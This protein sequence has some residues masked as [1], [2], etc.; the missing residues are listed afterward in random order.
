MLAWLWSP[1][2]CG[3]R[4]DRRAA[5][6]ALGWAGLDLALA[7]RSL[8]RPLDLALAAVVVAGLDLAATTVVVA[9]VVG[10]TVVGAV[11]MVIADV[12]VGAVIAVRD[13]TPRVQRAGSRVP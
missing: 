9:Q 1:H 2:R 5:A 8:A 3:P 7:T 11:A 10:G 4:P 6:V 13:V 12:V